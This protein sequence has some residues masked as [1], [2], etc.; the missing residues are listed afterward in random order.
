MLAATQD[1]FIK[2]L[3][4]DAGGTPDPNKNFT[5]LG[6]DQNVAT[7]FI[8]RVQTKGDPAKT[9]AAFLQMNQLMSN[10]YAEYTPPDCPDTP[11]L[12]A[13]VGAAQQA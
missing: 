8:N 9:Q 5:R 10:L 4:P 11:T 1:G 13:I 2:D 3:V 6:V 7:D 12:Q